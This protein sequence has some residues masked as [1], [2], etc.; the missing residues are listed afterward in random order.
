MSEALGRACS[1]P[2]REEHEPEE[3]CQ[4]ALG[5]ND[6]SYAYLATQLSALLAWFHLHVAL[7]TAPL[8]NT[9]PVM[10]PLPLNFGLSLELAR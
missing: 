8:K 6:F 7:L 9:V 2:T 1:W 3:R 5:P 10:S 4:A